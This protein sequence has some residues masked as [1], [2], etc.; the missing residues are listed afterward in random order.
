[1]YTANI[2][3]NAY[4]EGAYVYADGEQVGH[5]SYFPQAAD[6]D[7]TIYVYFHTDHSTEDVPTVEDGIHRLINVALDV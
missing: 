7:A 6:L 3:V 4:P 1:M 5:V 2:T